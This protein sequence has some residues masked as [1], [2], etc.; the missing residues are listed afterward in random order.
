MNPPSICRLCLKYKGKSIVHDAE[1]C[2]LGAS[3]LCRRCHHRGHLAVD[4]TAQYPQWE[5]PV[6][7]E[8]LIPIDIRLR[9]GINTHTSIAYTNPE[10]QFSEL[11]DITTIV[12]PDTFKEL[13]EFVESRGIKVE[14]VTKPS[15]KVLMKAV[16]KWGVANGYRIISNA[17]V[18]TISQAVGDEESAE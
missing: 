5:R 18:R 3:T 10:R 16:K 8:E 14:K 13:S 12:V 2:S 7:L 6:T 15:R 11:P 4:C 1:G 9:L 17:E